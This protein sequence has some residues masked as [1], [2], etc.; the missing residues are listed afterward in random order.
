MAVKIPRR[1]NDLR[2]DTGDAQLRTYAANDRLQV[3]EGSNDY[4]TILSARV[5]VRDGGDITGADASSVINAVIEQS[6][7]AYIPGGLT[8]HVQSPLLIKGVKC[9]SSDPGNP[10]NIIVDHG[11]EGIRLTGPD[12]SG[13]PTHNRT[14]GT[15]KNLVLQAGQGFGAVYQGVKLL[16]AYMATV[17]NISVYYPLTALWLYGESNALHCRGLMAFLF[18]T[19]GI[20]MERS[21]AGGVPAFNEI[22]TKEMGCSARTLVGQSFV[23][24][25]RDSWGCYC[26]GSVNKVW[27]DCEGARYAV[28][29]N[30]V[31]NQWRGYSECQYGPK[32]NAGA[33][34]FFDMHLYTESLPAIVDEDA[35]ATG[36]SGT[37]VSYWGNFLPR[38]RPNFDGLKALYRFNEGAGSKYALDYSGNNNL[39][40]YRAGTTWDV[41]SGIWGTVAKIDYANN[42]GPGA[43]PVGACDWSAAFSVLM[44]VRT[45]AWN[46]ELT[47]LEFSTYPSSGSKYTRVQSQGGYLNVSD[48]DGAT[49][50]NQAAV[51]PTA[52]VGVSDWRWVWFGFDQAARKFYSWD[53]IG[54]YS[55]NTFDNGRSFHGLPSPA[56]ISI[57]HDVFD[58]KGLTEGYCAYLAVWSRLPK[59]GEVVRFVNEQLPPMPVTTMQVSVPSAANSPGVV[60]QFATNAN[61]R[62]ECIA[63]DTW[64]F[65]PKGTFP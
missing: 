19:Y 16:N 12:G 27:M 64:I 48:Y 7:N 65:I 4:R 63:T 14:S 25:N 18:Y 45:A 28:E 23:W 61:G 56:T 40:T 37:D 13:D 51:S 21:L 58:L 31:E 17:E 62:Y 36:R 30:G 20:K 43:L 38:K 8:V 26:D 2:G 60:G 35:Y 9:L 49:G 24:D 1:L 10:A 6:G 5:D 41:T 57:G 33:N 3:K 54:G 52:V 15:V 39:I 32:V 46:Q 11:N 47:M 42:S 22:Y 59:F 55:E 44:L 34:S 50:Q 29:D 53:A